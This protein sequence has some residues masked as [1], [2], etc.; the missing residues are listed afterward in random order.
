MFDLRIF[1]TNITKYDDISAI[2]DISVVYTHIEKK[3]SIKLSKI[4][5]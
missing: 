1:N 3:V 5:I 2:S 4:Y